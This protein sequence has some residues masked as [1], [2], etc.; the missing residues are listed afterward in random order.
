MDRSLRAVAASAARVLPACACAALALAPAADAATLFS[1]DLES[2]SLSA[3]SPPQA[4][5][6]ASAH[7]QSQIVRGGSYAAR[8][9][10]TS[11]STS[12]AYVRR[13]LAAAQ[14]ELTVAADVR[15]VAAGTSGN[16]PLLRLFDP[17]GGRLLSLYRQNGYHD[18]LYVQHSGRYNPTNGTLALHG[19]ARLE[20]TIKAA[21]SAGEVTVKLDGTVIHHTTSASL[22]SAGVQTLQLGNDTKGQPFDVVADNVLATAPATATTSGGCGDAAPA[23]TTSDPGA[24]VV[25][26]GFEGGLGL[27]SVSRQG[28]AS[29]TTQSQAARSGCAGRISV[30]ASSTSRGNLT[31]ALPYG[32][33]ELWAAGWFNFEAQGTSTRW[34]L[35]TFRMFSYGKRVL[36]VS[37]QN[38]SASLFVRYPDGSGG[39]TIRPT[40][41]YP[42]Q[43]R[44]YHLRIHAIAN[45]GQSTV[46]VWL[47][48]SRIFATNSATLGTS[49]FTVQMLGADHGG[50]EGVIAFDEVVVKARS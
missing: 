47:D 33:R 30:S 12:Y 2:G 45:Y 14:T 9:S 40:G 16:V 42:A 28:D 1:D 48:G 23:P 15:I 35:P 18:R 3:W 41:L 26:D 38:G 32:T 43:K 19:W 37:R 6:G 31:K 5:S 25:S 49:R 46:E 20:V 7:V 36:D 27:W 22:G 24:A 44:W 21:G 50:Q 17:G 4:G 13:R 29:V 8:L 10:A 34:N 39:W 11:S